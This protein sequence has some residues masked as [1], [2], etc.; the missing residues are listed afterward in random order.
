MGPQATEKEEESWN[1]ELED[2]ELEDGEQ[3]HS[4]LIAAS[5]RGEKEKP[6]KRNHVTRRM[7]RVTQD[8]ATSHSQV[9]RAP[10]KQNSP[11]LPSFFGFSPR[12]GERVSSF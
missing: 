3:R 4:L 9:T 12:L 11:P 1:E 6:S 8:D 2:M 10:T 7:S 5:R